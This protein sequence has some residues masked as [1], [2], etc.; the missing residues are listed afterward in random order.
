[1][2]DT[3]VASSSHVWK[4]GFGTAASFGSFAGQ[5]VTG[6]GVGAGGNFTLGDVKAIQ[7]LTFPCSGLCSVC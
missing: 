2:T 6:M 5:M 1:M 4:K 7:H 3:E